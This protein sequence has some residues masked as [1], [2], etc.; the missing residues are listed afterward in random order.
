[1]IGLTL[2]A[3]GG[4]IVG[5]GWCRERSRSRA[6]SRRAARRN[7]AAPI[8]QGDFLLAAGLYALQP[9]LPFALGTEGVGPVLARRARADQ[10]QVGRRVLILYDRKINKPSTCRAGSDGQS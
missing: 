3:L 4:A 9:R 10:G 1:M 7:R 2:K 5:R 6:R 8:N